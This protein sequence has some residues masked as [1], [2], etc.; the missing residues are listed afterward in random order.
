[1]G[2]TF[3]HAVVILHPLEVYKS[4]SCVFAMVALVRSLDFVSL[5]DPYL[6]QSI[7]VLVIAI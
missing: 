6:Y 1:M 5:V 7:H 4:L 3:E 2:D